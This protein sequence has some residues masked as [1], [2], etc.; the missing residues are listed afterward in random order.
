MNPRPT[1][2]SPFGTR[3]VV[4]AISVQKALT[5]RYAPLGALLCALA[6]ACTPV[7]SSMRLGE[8]SATG[9]LPTKGTLLIVGGGS[10][11]DELVRH[12]VDLA[13]GPG[14]AR[15]A[16]LPMASS[17]AVETGAEKE[18]QLDSLGADSFV[19]NF[20]RAHAD[21]DSMVTAL[22]GATGI[23]FPGGDQSLLTAALQGSAALREI[24]ARFRAGAVVGGTSAGAAVMSDSM[25]TGNQFWPGMSAAVDSPSF[26]RISRR[27]IEIVPGFGFVRN[28]IVDQ[29][30]IRRQR[31]NRLFTV[32]LERPSLL[33]VGIDEGTALEVAPDGRWTVMGR[34]SVMILD[35][36]RSR[37]TSTASALGA[38]N[39]RV[40]VLPA[41]SIYDPQTGEATLPAR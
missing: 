29:H 2:R 20:T 34:S 3:S 36:R 32:V 8:P 33:G 30:F 22:R 31:E 14:K 15:I 5:G 16:I 38:A 26:S 41:G 11:P 6:F 40:S 9:F 25:I 7:A 17:E 28:A 4:R 12:F 13:G 21:D 24:Q 19:V 1:T 18:A 23:W 39:I 35:A 10:Q 37:I 27:S